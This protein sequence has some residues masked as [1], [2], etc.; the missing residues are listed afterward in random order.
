M[1]RKRVQVSLGASGLA[2]LV[3]VGAGLTVSQQRADAQATPQRANAQAPTYEVDPWFP[4]PFAEDYWVIGSVTGI[5][6][7]AADRLWV[8]HRGNQSL[9]G[10]ERGMYPNP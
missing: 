10:N 8:V 4:R 7:D 3:A 1:K 9:E 2:L 5:T 6:V